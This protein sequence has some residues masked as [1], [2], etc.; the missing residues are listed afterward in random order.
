[1][2][3]A[4]PTKEIT[5]DR[6]ADGQSGVIRRVWLEGATKRRLI[7]MG[8]TPGARLRVIKRAPLGDPI[9]IE[10]RGYT[11]TLRADDARRIGVVPREGNT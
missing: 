7:E 6:L 4:F 5:L 9:E 10:L 11:L 1:M 2:E 8:V 3:S